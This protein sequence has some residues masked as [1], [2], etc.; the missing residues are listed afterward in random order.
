MRE[1]VIDCYEPQNLR[2]DNG[3]AHPD[4]NDG[5]TLL[6]T[7]HYLANSS[8]AT[9]AALCHARLIHCLAMIMSL[10]TRACSLC[11]LDPVIYCITTHIS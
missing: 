7:D 2:S 9:S 4:R 5:L 11:R 1:P 3:S 10:S 6:Q 8:C